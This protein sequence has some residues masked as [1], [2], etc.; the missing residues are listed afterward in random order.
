MAAWMPQFFRT[1]NIT[2]FRDAKTRLL[3]IAWM[4]SVTILLHLEF[5]F[6]RIQDFRGDMLEGVL[7]KLRHP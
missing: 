6:L 4:Q 5:P 7:E 1:R 3:Q 2:S